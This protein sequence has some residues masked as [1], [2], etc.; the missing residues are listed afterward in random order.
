MTGR[1]AAAAVPLALLAALLVPLLAACASAPGGR[2]TPYDDV[3]RGVN[4]RRGDLGWNGI[5]VGMTRNQVERALGQRLGGVRP[6]A[7]GLCP[8]R[9]DAGVTYLERPLDLSFTG[10]TQSARL[11]SMTVLLPSGFSVHEVAERLKRKLRGLTWVPDRHHP[12]QPEELVAKPLYR[13]PGGGL[14]F[15][16]PGHGISLG[17]VCVD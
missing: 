2:V 3:L 5:Y 14:V 13:T 7:G 16:D 10:S 17:E 1:R 12:G 6:R 4:V 8:Q 9:Y 15:L 11:A